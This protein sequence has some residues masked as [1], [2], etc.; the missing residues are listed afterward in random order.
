MQYSFFYKSKIIFEIVY[1]NP[2]EMSFQKTF[3]IIIIIT[4]IV[5]VYLFTGA[6]EMIHIIEKTKGYL[7]HYSA[8]LLIYTP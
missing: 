2:A 1:W 7:T 3:D 6:K 8:V 5:I 4:I